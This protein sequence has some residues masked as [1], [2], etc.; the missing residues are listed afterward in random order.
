[1]QSSSFPLFILFNK[2]WAIP[3]KL[4]NKLVPIPIPSNNLLLIGLLFFFGPP[5]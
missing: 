5:L 1:M 2:M 4:K 3:N